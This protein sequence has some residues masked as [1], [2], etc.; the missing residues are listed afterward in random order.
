[1]ENGPTKFVVAFMRSGSAI[2]YDA[3]MDRAILYSLNVSHVGNSTQRR[4]YGGAAKCV[5][6]PIME[7]NECRPCALGQYWNEPVF[8]NDFFIAYLMYYE[9]L[10]I[11]NSVRFNL[12]NVLLFADRTYLKQCF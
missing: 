12:E 6:C 2:E 1:M 7:G 9:I 10:I 5:K 8:E 3:I 4:H 11:W